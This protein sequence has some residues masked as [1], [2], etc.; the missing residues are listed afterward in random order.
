MDDLTCL[1]G[2]KIIHSLFPLLFEPFCHHCEGLNTIYQH[3]AR[4]LVFNSWM[5]VGGAEVDTWLV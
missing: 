5:G 4:T 3:V 2:S 1:I